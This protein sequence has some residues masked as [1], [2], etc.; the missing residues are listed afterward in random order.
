M[1]TKPDS[2]TGKAD[3][4]VP[5]AIKALGCGTAGT[6][7]AVAISGTTVAIVS[8]ATTKMTSLC[9][10]MSN[11]EVEMSQIPLWN[12]CYASGTFGGTYTSQVVTSQPYTG[13][14]GVGVA[15]DPTGAPTVAYLGLANPPP[16]ED[17]GSNGAFVTT[18]QGTTWGTP[19][20]ISNGSMSDGLIMSQAG[21]CS[22]GICD[23][24]DVTGI[25]P[26]IAYDG[27]GN[28]MVPYQDL[29][30]GF[31]EDDQAKADLELGEASGGSYSVLT[32]D[33]SRGAGTYNRIAI[34]PKGL[35]AVL[36]YNLG[37]SPGIYLDR[38]AVAGSLSSQEAT[39][40][41]ID[42]QIFDGNIGAQLGFAISASGI[43]GVAYYNTTTFVLEYIQS[44]DGT[45]WSPAEIVDNTGDTGYQPSLAFDADNNPA[46][47]YYRCSSGPATG[48]MSSCSNSSDGLY[49]ARRSGTT[50]TP[51]LVSA[52]PNVTDGYFPAVGFVN[53]KAVIAFQEF[54]VDDVSQTTA[55]TWWVAEEP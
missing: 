24:G 17:C 32:I 52:I 27:A 16:G 54:T 5:W 53:G 8:L 37:S 50:W 55:Y 46:V 10:D 33:V 11:G 4:G 28:A 47:A 7:S 42:Q 30:F 45:T 13:A 48:N 36:T 1:Q 43:Y 23:M 38:Q 12:V 26:A 18:L 35:P 25:W 9:T 3:A 2:S 20:Q 34:D 15:F 19:T 6:Q 49:L 31:G 39:G 21:N 22:Q 51:S 40:G 14:T 29:H 41:W 44:T